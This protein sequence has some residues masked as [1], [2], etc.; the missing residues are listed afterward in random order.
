MKSLSVCFRFVHTIVFLSFIPH[1]FGSESRDH[2]S[3]YEDGRLRPEVRSTHQGDPTDSG[4]RTFDLEPFII[5]AWANW[6]NPEDTH[7]EALRTGLTGSRHP[8][9]ER[10]DSIA[11]DRFLSLFMLP[12]LGGITPEEVSRQY[13]RDRTMEN[14]LRFLD[15]ATESREMMGIR[16]PDYH[17]DRLEL[18][19]W[20]RESVSFLGSTR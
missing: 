20:K 6:L 9:A 12:L 19:R 15:A 8:M 18:L 17:Q 10:D 4:E 13:A 7:V 3:P 1:G 14:K 16:N 5:R 11:M 2:F